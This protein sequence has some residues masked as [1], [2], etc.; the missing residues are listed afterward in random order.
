MQEA[1][2]YAFGYI[3]GSG[4]QYDLAGNDKS[5]MMIVLV[6]LYVAFT[7]ILL[8]NLL[9]AFL[10]YIY[11]GIQN[12]ASS[13]GSY[14]RCKIIMS[15]VR[16]WGIP[17]GKRWIHFLKRESDVEKDE[18]TKNGK[19]CTNLIL[20]NELIKINM[21][22]KKSHMEDH[23]SL[24]KH[25]IE[26]IVSSKLDV[27]KKN[28]KEEHQLLNNIMKVNCHLLDQKLD[29]N[30]DKMDAIEQSHKRD[31]QLLY[32]KIELL[33]QAVNEKPFFQR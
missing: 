30:N 28:H 16:P 8:L 29:I 12:K 17:M 27:A 26:T 18:N 11:S 13:V 23:H 2:L 22:I 19:E 32:E 4:A 9:I 20:K 21:N 14:E 1:Y 6:V 5:N 10:S 24:L 31:Y 3:S 7:Q 25:K 15:Q 33:L